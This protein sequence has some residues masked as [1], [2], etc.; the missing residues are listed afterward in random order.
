MHCAI[1]LIEAW[2]SWVAEKQRPA[3]RVL[4]ESFTMRLASGIPTA[5]ASGRYSQVVP[6]P[7]PPW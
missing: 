4:T 5:V 2:A 3:T 7:A 1:D 6:V